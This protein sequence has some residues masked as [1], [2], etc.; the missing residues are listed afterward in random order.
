VFY[1]RAKIH[2]QAGNGGDGAATFRREKFVPYGGPD[3]GDGGRGGSV[4]LVADPTLRTLIEF[5]AHRHLRAG[6]GG[7]GGKQQRHGAAGQ[8]LRLRVPAGTMVRDEATGELLADLVAPG[9]EALVARGGRGG[10]GN[11]HFATPTQQAPKFA[12]KGEPGEGRWLLLELK[13]I[14]DVGIIGY[15]NVG[16]STLL[17]ATTRARPKIADYPFTTLAPN[18][19]V[20]VVDDES[21]VLADIPG[22]IEGAHTGAGLGHEFLRHIERTRLLV[23]LLDGTS[24]DAVGDFHKVNEELALYNPIL[25][26]RPQIVAV[27]KLDLPAAQEA[28]PTLR[29]RLAALGYSVFGISAATGRGVRELLGAVARRLRELPLP[30]VIEPEALPVLR[31]RPKPAAAFTVARQGSA[32]VVRGARV[33]RLAVQ[34]D[35]ENEEARQR[36]ERLLRQWGV[37]AALQ[38]AGVQ[39]GDTVRIG[40]VELTWK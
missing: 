2:V 32:Y 24:A 40:Q 17:A 9:Q 4:Y 10:L 14:A 16:K 15:P 12:E 30:A 13:L 6:H 39:P 20:A 19:G 33:E 8:D 28:W 21:F 37:A 34:T 23:H 38:E 3:G 27:N 22:L 36:F 29:Q 18:L 11:V 35:W 5:Q 26:A 1:D 25:A 31:P 7:R